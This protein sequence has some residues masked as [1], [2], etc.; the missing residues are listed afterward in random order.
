V[1]GVLLSRSSFDPAKTPAASTLE[2]DM[3][4]HGATDARRAFYL[5]TFLFSLCH[6]T[7]G[8]PPMFEEGDGVSRLGRNSPSAVT[9][10]GSSVRHPAETRERGVARW[11]EREAALVPAFSASD[12]TALAEVALHV[13]SGRGRVLVLAFEDRDRDKGKSTDE[14]GI[15]GVKI[16]A[17]KPDAERGAPGAS[18]EASGTTSADGAA[19]LVLSS[20]SYR[21]VQKPAPGYFCPVPEVLAVVNPGVISTI[22]EFPNYRRIQVTGQVFRDDDK[23][24]VPGASEPG[25]AGVPVTLRSPAALVRVAR[26]A[27]NGS[28]AFDE[29]EPETVEV[30]AELPPRFEATTP[31]IVSLDLRAGRPPPLLFGQVPLPVPPPTITVQPSDLLLAD[32]E[33]GVIDL[34]AESLSALTF[35]WLRDG[36]V[37]SAGTQSKLR[38]GPAVPDTSGIYQVRVINETGSILSRPVQIKVLRDLAYVRWA[39]GYGVSVADADTERDPDVDGFANLVEFCLGLSPVRSDPRTAV[40]LGSVLQG[41]RRVAA[42]EFSRAHVAQTVQVFLQ[43]S[44]DLRE[45]RNIPS[46]VEILNRA[47]DSDRVRI[48]DTARIDRKPHRF[49]RL[50][51]SFDPPV[52][53]PP[54]LTLERTSEGPGIAL[55]L[56][57]ESGMAY[58]IETSDDLRRWNRFRRVTTEDGEVTLALPAFADFGTR[59]YRV[60]EGAPSRVPALEISRPSA[61]TGTLAIALQ[62]EVGKRYLV[63]WSEDLRT[64]HTLREAAAEEGEAVVT[65]S[66]AAGRPQR[67]Y[68]VIEGMPVEPPSLSLPGPSNDGGPWTLTLR[69]RPGVVYAVQ[70]SEDLQT[71]RTLEYTTTLEGEAV[72][73]ERTPPGARQR[74]F[75]AIEVSA[76]GQPALTL[77]PPA[78]ET[79]TLVLTLIAVR[80]RS[81]SIQWS[82]DLRTWH[83][84]GPV[85]VTGGRGSLTDRVLPGSRQRFYRALGD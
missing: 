15:P 55:H 3:N 6:S 75:R 39:R 52:V 76:S 45:W 65:D 68:R 70:W 17:W 84:L 19:L 73:T 53:A 71:W 18:P 12:P 20:G 31:R 69:G 13:T 38:I 11:S 58:T 59:F 34:V 1:C 83:D 14:P 35:E 47:A 51:V 82:D 10:S 7:V 77:G 9:T 16:E 27:D 72:V 8:D 57:G 48:L 42:L 81:Y 50:G 25:V 46:A 61:T 2:P 26:T 63:E 78:P 33:E 5:A 74:F 41:A 54:L 44:D 64:W 62:G 79:G 43:A 36:V 32:G 60:S 66:A 80:D 21:L 23:N 22:V 40:T 67:F 4:S 37:L 28:F 29:V 24:G 56:R 85:Q 30:E 49:L